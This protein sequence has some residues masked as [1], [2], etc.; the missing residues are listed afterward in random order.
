MA[1]TEILITKATMVKNISENQGV[2]LELTRAIVDDLLMM[3]S[4]ALVTSCRVR[5]DDF[6][7]F[8]L[9]HTTA[10]FGPCSKVSFRMGKGLKVMAREERNTK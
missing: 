3:A 10:G 6:G 5:L 7:T 8:K 9:R 2:P 4:C 1:A